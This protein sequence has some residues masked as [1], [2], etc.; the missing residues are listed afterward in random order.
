MTITWPDVIAFAPELSTVDVAAQVA[1]LAYIN[2][3]FNVSE[4]GGSTAPMLRLGMIYLAAHFGTITGQ[5]ANGA[6]GPVTKESVGEISREYMEASFST[7][8]DL[9]SSSYGQMY[10][11]LVRQSAARAPIVI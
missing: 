6:A 5:G 11:T 3:T 9:S 2:A 10:R 7:G 4:W 1:I 8:S